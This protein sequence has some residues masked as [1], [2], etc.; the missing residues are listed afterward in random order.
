[1]AFLISCS[2][3]NSATQTKEELLSA[4][5]FKMV[6]A[7]TPQQQAHLRALPPD[8]VSTVVRNGTNFFVFPDVKNEQLY[9]GQDTQYQKYQNLRLERQ[10]A[11]DS[12]QAAQM[13][14]GEDAD[15]GS[16]SSWGY[17]Q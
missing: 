9:V 11:L 12:A 10:M 5:G 2:T 4:A 13:Y 15:W 7:T 6:P 16:W 17:Y 8:T 14:N 1:M 3:T